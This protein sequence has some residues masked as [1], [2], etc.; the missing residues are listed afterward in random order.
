MGESQIRGPI[1]RHHG[2][3]AG[4]NINGR[5]AKGCKG[6]FALTLEITDNILGEYAPPRLRTTAIEEVT[7]GIFKIPVKIYR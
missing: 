2:G 3:G 4:M 6:S 1:T 7:P 5:K